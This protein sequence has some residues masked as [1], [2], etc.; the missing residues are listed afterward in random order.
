[1]LKRIIL[2]L[3]FL[4]T[5]IGYSQLADFNFDVVSTAET[6]AGNGTVQMTVSNTTPGSELIYQLYLAPDFSNSVAE[7]TSD[8]FGSLQSGNYRIIA[9]QTLNGSSSSQQEDIVIDDLVV[10]LDFDVSYETFTQCDVTGTLSV[11]ITSGNP[12]AY[13]IISGPVIVPL[14]S[15]NEFP[16]LPS[17]TYI[18]RVFDECEDALSKTFTMHLA[19][20]SLGITPGTLPVV[21]DSCTSV[22][23]STV[24][25]STPGTQIIYPL[26]IVYAIDPPDGSP[27]QIFTENI[28]SG[29]SD[30][31]QLLHPFPLF[32]NQAYE[33]IIFI[34]DS[35]GKQFS[36]TTA[37]NPNPSLRLLSKDAPCATYYLGLS[38]IGFM[39][40]YTVNFDEAPE[41]FDPATYNP[42]YPGP[43]YEPNI[44]FGSQENVVPFGNYVVSIVD[45]CGRTE[46]FSLEIKEK[47]L[48][49]VVTKASGK[50]GV[51]LG[52][53]SV[54]IPDDRKIVYAVITIA[55]PSYTEPLPSDIT[56]FVGEDGILLANLPVGDYEIFLID[57]CGYEY[58]IQ[59][60][61]PEFEIKG[62]IAET[63]PNCDPGSGSVKISSGNG[64][65]ESV[66]I[67]QAPLTYMQ[68]L[69]QDISFN[70]DPDSGNLFMSDLPA[71]AYTFK[72]IDE[73]GFESETMSNVIGYTSTPNGYSLFRNCGSFNLGVFDS[74]TTVT[75]QKYWFQKFH[76]GTNTWGHPYTGI[77]YAEGSLPN[78]SN[79]IPLANFSMVYNLFITGEFRIIKTFESYNNGNENSNCLEFFATFN[80]SDKLIING[81]YSLDCTGGSAP[82]DI[83]LDVVGVGPFSYSIT[84]PFAFDNGNNNVFTNLNPGVYRFEVTDACGSEKGI[85]VEVG[86]L[87]PLA[88]ANT[89]ES[90]LVCRNDTNQVGVF[91]LS[92]QNPQILGNQNPNDYNVT[93]HLNQQD[94]NSGNAPLDE[95]YTNISNPQTI[96]ARVTHKVLDVCYAT[97]SF[98]I[99]IGNNPIL[100]PTVPVFVC[101][102]N[103]RTLSADPGFDAYQWTTG[104]TTPSIVV[105]QPGIYGVT[106]KNVYQDFTCD[107]SKEFI[108][109]GSGIASFVSISTLD[110]TSSSNT[111]TVL[112]S[113][114]GDY[115]YSLDDINYQVENTFT[116]LLPGNY[117]VYVKDIHGCGTIYDTFSLLNYPNF[118]TPNGDG[119]NDTWNIKFAS[120]EPNMTIDIFDRYGKFIIKLKGDGPGWDGTYNGKLL[121]STDYWFVVTRENGTIHKGH[122]AM[123]R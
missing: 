58:T 42:L 53:I 31:L 65:L 123:K 60:V 109:T 76:T 83:V 80:I 73:C 41:D 90:M 88:R 32:G 110:W 89:P 111:I 75:N 33:L 16:G 84:T 28:T 94:A 103:T 35:C 112:V 27:N 23:V 49:P 18:I 19:A 120:L 107:N 9:T 24:I 99:F 26:S 46:S 3:F 15:S 55:P 17:G 77:S 20:N 48:D 8:T 113:G 10:D 79:S 34:T 117:I 70:I 101:E 47:E 98:P 81:A 118:F 37:I 61:V 95:A 67:I 122:F 39:P 7:T 54:G 72:G 22:Q 85:T 106:V 121:P 96:Y 92:N 5:S 44:N 64:K 74:N 87:V 82:S 115:L 14:Q 30:V 38:V 45:F 97:T 11:N 57:D 86:N 13:E 29:P 105:T 50:C 102:G 71:G 6:C 52:L 25:T 114:S 59:S 2:L 4:V 93:Y 91:I 12:S 78:T 116:Q 66:T 119:Y 43:I 69:P 100:T 68:T 51:E 62:I 56:F 40:P 1:M 108:V 104:E 21:Y 36:L 63:L